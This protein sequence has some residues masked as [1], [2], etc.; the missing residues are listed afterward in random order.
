MSNRG[1]IPI[2]DLKLVEELRHKQSSIDALLSLTKAINDNSSTLNLFNLYVK[3]LREEF[4]Y[5]KVFFLYK[6]KNGWF[7]IENDQHKY[8]KNLDL[9]EFLE[10]FKE[11]T[12][13]KQDETLIGEFDTIVPVIENGKPLAYVMIEGVYNKVVDSVEE[14][15]RFLETYTNVVVL[16]AEKRRLMHKEMEQKFERKE[17]LMA[18]EIQQALIPS[19]F[20]NTNRCQFAAEYIPHSAVGGDSYDVIPHPNED[21]VFITM[22]DVSGKGV[23]AA[24]L[25]ANFQATLRSA[26]YREKEYE[27]FAKNINSK[28]F[29]ITKGDRFISLFVA[30]ICLETNE[31]T[32]LNFGHNP[33]YLFTEGRVVKLNKGSTII[34]AFDELPFIEVGHEKFFGQT[35]LF[36]FT[37][38]LVDVLNEKD[39]RF[40]IERLENYLYSQEYNSPDDL[41]KTL[42]H[43]IEKYKGS[44]EFSDDITF[45]T[46]MIDAKN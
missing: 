24:L 38:G 43:I 18:A 37:D 44:Q 5:S 23:S 30:K 13:L 21:S 20:P 11:I 32:Y 2:Q 46:T 45:L 40:A 31:I 7:V 36:T 3:T 28:V 41:N 25:M 9:L 26:I 15:V 4:H 8:F 6:T 27:V 16:A 17:L 12:Y 34:G 19:S 39:Q 33:P 42:I 10:P 1:F 35:L 22:A 29:D 14:E